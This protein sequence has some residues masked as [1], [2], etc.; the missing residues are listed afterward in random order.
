MKV[1]TGADYES[2]DEMPTKKI[3]KRKRKDVQE[4]G[5]DEAEESSVDEKTMTRGSKYRTA[6]YEGSE[7]GS[8]MV[9][10]E[11]KKQILLLEELAKQMREEKE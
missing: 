2:E 3:L 6:V 5:A 4:F 8:K 7:T 9:D 1:A 11:T 10:E